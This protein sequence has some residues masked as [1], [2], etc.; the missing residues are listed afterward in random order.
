MIANL[1]K[2]NRS[3][4][5]FD[6]NF[7]VDQ[8]TLNEL[9]DLGRLSASAA[10]LQPL[11]YVISNDSKINAKIFDCL[12][13]AAYLKQWPGPDEGQRPSAYIIILGDN[14]ISSNVKWDHGIAGQTILL[15]AREKNL[16]GC[17]IASINI[18]KLQ[19][20]LEIPENLEILIVLA[21][22]KPIEE[23]VIEEV[24]IDGNIKYW[25]D[26]KNIHHVPKR[27]LDEIIIKKYVT[28]HKQEM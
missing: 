1:V 22:G 13:W 25:R 18:K 12:K 15:G 10:N 24:G 20:L 6:Q 26:E 19:T 17:M 4:R 14:K 8:K 28:V 11:K 16:A 5:R 2:Q 27:S 9:V 23:V 3:C 7:I 21:I